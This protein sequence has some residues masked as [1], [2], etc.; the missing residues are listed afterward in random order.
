MLRC[1]V[2]DPVMGQ[3]YEVRAPASATLRCIRVVRVSEREG[4]WASFEGARGFCVV[5][6][7]DESVRAI[8]FNIVK[9]CV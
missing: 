4:C 9:G 6:E 2:V 5:S 7:R 3:C 8:N 1:V